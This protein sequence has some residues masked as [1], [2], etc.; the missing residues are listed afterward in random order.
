MLCFVEGMPW[1]LDLEQLPGGE[2]VDIIVGELAGVGFYTEDIIRVTAIARE[3]FLKP[4]GMLIPDM[5]RV[6]V[7]LLDAELVEVSGTCRWPL[8]LFLFLYASV[9]FLRSTCNVVLCL[10]QLFGVSVKSI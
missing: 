3:R 9:L 4:G 8:L 10:L 5:A 1:W 2:K 7:G 6:Y